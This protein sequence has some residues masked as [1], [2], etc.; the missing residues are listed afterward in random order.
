MPEISVIIPCYNQEKYIAECLDSVLA[1]TF[2]DYEVIVVNDGS[3]DN[4][5]E[6]IKK[7]AEKYPQ[8]KLIN[9]VNQGLSATRNNAM[10]H[11]LGTY[12]YPLDGDDKIDQCCL[13]KLYNMITTTSYRAIG[14]ETMFFD[15]Q[16]ELLNQPKLTKYQM[17]GRY[18]GCVVSALYYREDFERFG[19]F[20]EDFSRIGGEDMDY[21]LNYIDKN[22]SIYR[23]PEVLFYYRLKNEKSY[24][25]S[26]S[27]RELK[28]RMK[29]KR[30]LLMRYHPKMRFWSNFYM[31]IETVK[32]IFYRKRIKENRCYYKVFGITVYKKYL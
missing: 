11:A 25:N 27:K 1:Q 23:L 12:F 17:Y 21:W 32:H 26:Y 3:T 8:I 22:L 24:W 28:K 4:S 18:S 29:Q 30:Q 5:A 2:T 31:I 13:E 7:Y 10:K 19:G 16:N 6:I 15:M 14:C 9:Q 20:K